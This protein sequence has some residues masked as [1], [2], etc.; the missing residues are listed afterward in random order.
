MFENKSH[1]QI[2]V[3]PLPLPACLSR[4]FPPP[5][6]STTFFQIN[7]LLFLLTRG[8]GSFL[9]NNHALNR[10]ESNTQEG[11]YT[12]F[13]LFFS[14]TPHTF[15]LFFSLA[16]CW[17]TCVPSSSLLCPGLVVFFSSLPRM[18]Q[19]HT[20]SYTTSALPLSRCGSMLFFSQPV[21]HKFFPET[22][23]GSSP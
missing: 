2:V 3:A 7:F 20:I 23:A 13:C 15:L 19:P 12:Y 21:P 1:T 8:R 11:H 4:G 6:V 16:Y 17:L 10:T 5:S 14:V 18:L 22:G 9:S